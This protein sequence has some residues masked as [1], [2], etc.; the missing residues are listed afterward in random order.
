MQWQQIE[1]RALASYLGFAVGDALGA[2]TEF[3]RPHEIQAK[4]QI[5]KEIIGGGWLHLKPGMVTDDTEMCLALGD[6]LIESGTM[7]E[8]TVAE[9]FLLWMKSK[10][11]DIGHTIRQ[12]ISRYKLFG[13]LVA[14]YSEYSASNGSLMRNL[15]VIIATLNTPELLNDWS[16][17]QGL[18]THNNEVAEAGMIMLSTATHYAILNAQEA[19]LK[20]FFLQWSKT[21]PCFDYQR[22]RKS[23][24]GRISDTIKTVLYFFFNTTDFESCLVGV[25][26]AGGDTDTNAALAGMLAAPFYG[27]ES[28][29][30]RWLKKMDKGVLKKIEKQ[31][32]QLIKRFGD[33]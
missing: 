9:R 18:I 10:P 13:E 24:D 5:H 1:E 7:D 29:P 17:R 4:Y 20:S 28:I 14:E 2:T 32:H 21:C 15:P 25:V 19:P 11:A 33:G 12:G 22:Y 30:S 16:R 6:A 23:I 26:N 27:I 31:T 3:M 8:K